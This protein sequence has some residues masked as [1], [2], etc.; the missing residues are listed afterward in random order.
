MRPSLLA[1]PPVVVAC[2]L[3]FAFYEPPSVPIKIAPPVKVAQEPLNVPEGHTDHRI[4]VGDKERGYWLFSPQKRSNA[5]VV[6]LHGGGSVKAWN[7]AMRYGF[8][9]LAKA[10]GFTVAYPRSELGRWMYAPEAVSGYSDED[11]RFIKQMVADLKQETGARRVYFT[12][13]SNGAVMA[14]EVAARH[15]EI[16]DA[17][18]PVCGT[19]TV[20]SKA[21]ATKPTAPV[22]MM[23]VVGAKDPEMPIETAMPTAELWAKAAGATQKLEEGENPLCRRQSAG[24]G[25]YQAPR[26]RMAPGT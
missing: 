3:G 20:R 21:F 19:A 1:V 9:A 5:L 16:V 11:F 12:G 6:V 26:P 23:L 10:E 7:E 25:L 22:P 18:A 24:A 8:S 14:H 17:M 13:F 2:L 4:M 15:P